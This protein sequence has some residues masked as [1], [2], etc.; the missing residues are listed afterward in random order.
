MT[1]KLPI[2]VADPGRKTNAQAIAE[3]VEL[4]YLTDVM[5]VLDVTYGLGNFWSDWRPTDLTACDLNPEKAPDFIADF[6]K[7][8]FQDRSFDA[9]VIDP[10]YKLQGKP[11]SGDFDERYGIEIPAR[12]QDR[13]QLCE[14]GVI[15]AA[16][17]ADDML[18]VKCQNQ[19]CSKKVRWQTTIFT[20]AAVGFGL[21]TQLQ[22]NGYRP[23]PSGRPQRTPRN[24]FSTLL[25]LK[26]GW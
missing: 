25:V 2:M 3:C 17:V 26:R 5:S 13:M 8:P 12:W 11:A 24:N 14:D 23:Q 7:L 15:E 10:P 18:F 1:T 6:R 19:V 16:R 4:G 20:E 22:V 9:V 21:V